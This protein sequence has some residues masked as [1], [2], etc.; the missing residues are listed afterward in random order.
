MTNL[1]LHFDNPWLLLLLIPVLALALYPYFRLAKRYRRTRNRICSLVLHVT[2]AV[3]A[4]TVLSGLHFTY[5]KPNPNNELILLVDSSKSSDE[6]KEKR[7]EFIRAVIDESGAAGFKVGVVKFGF[8]SVYAVPLTSRTD[9]VFE[10]YSESPEPRADATD[11]AAALDYASGLFSRANS[12]KILI[13]SD[14][15]ETDGNAISAVQTLVSS[16]IKVDTAYFGSERSENEVQIIG[17]ECPDY[18]ISVGDNFNMSLSVRSSFAGNAA[19]TLQDFVY[20]EETNEFTESGVGR[21]QVDIKNGE[22]TISFGYSFEVSGLHRL[23]FHIECAGDTLSENNGYYTY[24]NLRVYDNIL[25]IERSEHEA[26][27]LSEIL[28]ERYNTVDVVNVKDTLKMPDSLDKLRAYDQVILLNVG[29]K[30]MPQGFDAILYDYVEKIGGGLFTVGG[31]RINE[32]TK[33]EESNVYNRG[34]MQNTLLQKMIPVEAVKYTP[35]LGVVVIID[36]SG[37]MN[38]IDGTTGKKLLELAKEGAT[39]CLNAMTE[40]DY[41]GVMTLENT[42]NEALG[43]TPVTEEYKIVQAINSIDQAGGSTNFAPAFRHAGRALMASNQVQ[44]KHIILVT[45]GAPGD[46]EEDYKQAII[47]NYANGITCSM[48]VVGNEATENSPLK[49]LIEE[50]GHGRYYAVRNLT[51]LSG[52]M[53]E[54]LNVSAIKDLT[55]DKD[56]M[57]PKIVTHD[58]MLGEMLGLLGKD[59]YEMPKLYGYYGTK[60]KSSDKVKSI[61]NVELAPLYAQWK[62]GNGMVGSFM[63]DLSGKWSEEFLSGEVGKA[64][65]YGAINSLLP[66]SDIRL[67]DVELQLAEENYRSRLSVIT[68]LKNDEKIEITVTPPFGGSDEEQKFVYT[69]NDNYTDTLITNTQAGLHRIT[70]RKIG[71]DGLTI[72]EN[73]VFRAVSYSAE[74]D[75]FVDINAGIEKLAVAAQTGRGIAV[76]EAWQIFEQT[77][78]YLHHKSNPRVFLLIVAL[79][80][81]V[82]DIAVRKFK[83]KW[84]HEIV[85]EHK[86]AKAK[87]GQR[88]DSGRSN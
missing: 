35:P 57:T 74:F 16:G 27:I 76:T 58:A 43:L 15:L 77:E 40:R 33:E 61:L 68:Q 78:R 47:N 1:K 56:G 19:V 4:V 71:A 7:D 26:D 34:E 59:G 55:F 18:H 50:E 64:F 82:L 42:Y 17:V 22:Q 85:R 80:L 51:E 3:L 30:D 75:A 48:V 32:S 46:K 72:S 84:I 36:R 5:D 38:G 88:T 29:N 86:E 54:D 20:D 37:S 65:I 69:A 6:V 66:V 10:K 31:N 53:R 52:I 24:I 23:Q 87:S 25:I 45:D 83:F 49:K 13:I 63:S 70:V 11:I 39:S 9:G 41:Y 44:K 12:G 14:G 2:V 73:S 62:F 79:I 81:F 67:K 60:L 8:D 28:S 21:E